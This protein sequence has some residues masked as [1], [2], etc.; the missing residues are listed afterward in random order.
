VRETRRLVGRFVFTENDARLAPR[1]KRAP[2]Y[3][4]S[5]SITEWFL[6][7]HAC[8]PAMVGE[9]L[10]EG[11]L[12]LNNIT[13]PG[14]VPYRAMLPLELDNFVV[15]VCA[16]SSHIGWGAIRL[17]PTWMSMAEAAAHAIVIAQRERKTPAEVNTDRLLRL[18]AEKRVLLSFFNDIEGKEREAWYPAVQYLGT[19]GFFGTY[20]AQV[21]EPLRDALAHVWIAAAVEHAKGA[22][23]DRTERARQVLAAEERGGGTI[24]AADFVRQLIQRAERAATTRFSE[25]LLGE[26]AIVP[27]N[28]LSRGD[29]CRIVFAALNPQGV[30]SGPAAAAVTKTEF[31]YEQAPFPQCHASTIA[32][33]TGGLV[34]AWFGGTREGH[35]DVGIWVSRQENGRWAPPVEVANGVQADGKRHPTWNPVLFQPKSGP[36]LLFYKVGPSPREWWG[37]MRTSTDGGK[38]WSD[39]RRLPDGIL[40]PVKNKPVELADGSLLCP[41]STETSN[42][43]ER[44]GEWRVHF[45][46]TAD[47][48]QTW[49]KA[50][51][52]TKDSE[53]G[54]Q[55]SIL[56]H[57]G[58]VLQ[59]IGR[60]RMGRLFTTWSRD[61]GKTWSHVQPTAL[62]NPSS[63]TDAVTLADGRHVL[64]YN[65]TAHGRTPLSVGLSRD[66]FSW[67]K[68]IDLETEPGEYSY[69]AVIQ[70]RD[71]MIHV[72]YTWMRERVKHVVIDPAKLAPSPASASSVSSL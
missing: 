56:F 57:G 58:T 15:P 61:A 6:D 35:P 21:A 32:E 65:D 70:T 4:D 49:T 68:P 31:I 59:A 66:G 9:S 39:A 44:R 36:L 23:V 20:N 17:E 19:Q 13:F 25:S 2:V 3:S 14:Q 71:G 72:T 11:E 45:E 54:I 55:P 26:L 60:T 40:G 42:T 1:L 50:A 29:A 64:I 69:P 52:S 24:T 46:R 38:N 18:L 8:S 37:V 12:L 10:W 34:T 62:P 53:Q 33:S 51:P 16:S 28:P 67:S 47:L 30:A 41:S 48:G 63:G 7:S 22:D 27:T 43:P 5:I